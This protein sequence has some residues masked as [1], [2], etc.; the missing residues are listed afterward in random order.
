MG[1]RMVKRNGFVTVLAAEAT[2][3][4]WAEV[5]RQQYTLQI[6][7]DFRQGLRMEKGC[8]KISHVLQR[9]PSRQHTNAT[10]FS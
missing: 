8:C 3:Q 9:R 7:D 5:V 2:L 4:P 1:Y 10:L 6:N